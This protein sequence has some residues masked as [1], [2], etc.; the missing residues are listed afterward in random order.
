[1]K[2]TAVTAFVLATFLTFGKSMQVKVLT[3]PELPTTEASKQWTLEVNN[4]DNDYPNLAQSKRGVYHTYCLNMKNVGKDV[5]DVKVQ[6]FRN[7]SN[8][9]TKYGLLPTMESPELSQKDG[10]PLHVSNFGL[11]EE[12]T[13]LNIVITWKEKGAEREYQETF[14]FHQK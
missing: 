3:I 10:H 5:H 9:N 14:T 4:P 11:S 8:L 12:A 1:M 7:E 2:R 6:L 13:D